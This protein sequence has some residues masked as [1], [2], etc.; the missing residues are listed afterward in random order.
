MINFI[1]L[2]GWV[3]TGLV[4]GSF[5]FK[6]MVKLRF[7]NFL[8]TVTWAFYGFLKSDIPL[9]SVNITLMTI[10]LFWFYKNVKLW[11]S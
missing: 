11:K 5:L 1:D 3:A 6:D 7:T 2:V 9:V 8:A 4:I 10:H